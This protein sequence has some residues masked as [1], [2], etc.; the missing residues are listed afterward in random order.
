VRLTVY[1]DYSVRMLM[2]LVVA[3]DRLAT[4][5]EVAEAYDISKAHLTK[6]AH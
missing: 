3:R 4:I 2:Y 6:V 5:A 1:T